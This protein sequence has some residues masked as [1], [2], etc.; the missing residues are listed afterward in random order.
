[1]DQQQMKCFRF[2]K[3]DD[4]YRICTQYNKSTKATTAI[5]ELCPD[6]W[7]QIFEYFNAIEL[8][9][10]LVHITIAGDEVLFNR[11]HHFRL[12]KLVLDAD[13]TTLPEKL[14]LDQVISLELHQDSC[15]STIEQ[16]LE[17]R[18][19]KLIGLPEWVICFL[20][21]ISNANIKLE[22]LVLTVPGIGSLYDLLASILPLFSLRRLAIYANES[23]EKVKAGAL[24]LAQTKIEQF[25]LHSCSSIS[26]NELSYILAGLSNIRFLD[27][28]LFHHN[29]NSFCWFTFP[30]LRYI[31]LIL[32]EVSFEWIIQ[33]VT[34]MPSL[35]KL[36]L[37]GLV[38]GEGF[39]INHKWLNLFESCSSL[40]I[41]QANLSLERDT[42]Y[43]C[44]NMIQ[45][46]LREI[47]LNLRCIEDYYDYYFTGE[48]QQRW[49]NLSG[50]I[51]K[52][53]VHSWQIMN[54]DH[55]IFARKSFISIL[56]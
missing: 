42:N 55:L 20:R 14:S 33:L 36:K 26:W 29:R 5:E 31:C 1:M 37:K 41:V 10:S 11:N 54:K 7:Q 24:S 19:L 21:K 22:Q 8:F 30:K 18:S 53:P 23:E 13:I 49:W 3:R 45:A 15:L 25:I 48:S 40:A 32:V 50:M 28:T 9:F 44:I 6:I 38:D 47:N 16:C 39:I 51:M 2:V 4:R 35:V 17:L 56:F 43:F 12:R 27:I 34:T 46:A 52:Q